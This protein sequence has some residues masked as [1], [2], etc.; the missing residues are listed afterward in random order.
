MEKELFKLTGNDRKINKQF[1][2][3][4]FLC[5]K[6]VGMVQIAAL[7]LGVLVQWTALR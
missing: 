4:Q 1:Q 6:F 2:T 3:K 7:T 5:W